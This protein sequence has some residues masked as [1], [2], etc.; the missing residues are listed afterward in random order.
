MSNFCKR[1]GNFRTHVMRAALVLALALTVQLAPALPAHA[2]TPP[3][4]NPGCETYGCLYEHCNAHY[5]RGGSGAAGCQYGT[6]NQMLPD[7]PDNRRFVEVLWPGT[8]EPA[9]RAMWDDVAFC[10][11][12]WRWAYNGPSGYHGGVQFSAS[13]W[14]AFGGEEFAPYAF[15]ALAEQQIAVA[16]RVAFTGWARPDGSHVSPQGPRAWPHCGQVLSAP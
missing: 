15:Q 1:S 9:R 7:G 16:E 4:E 6:S 8:Y 13:T 14:R 11:S 3:P 5:G 12:T 2:A 10:E